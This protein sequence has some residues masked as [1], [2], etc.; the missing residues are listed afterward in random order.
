MRFKDARGYV[1]ELR[2]GAYDKG[3]KGASALKGPDGKMLWNKGEKSSTVS[4]AKGLERAV[5]AL[6]SGDGGG[7]FV[8]ELEYRGGENAGDID[9]MAQRLA[10]SGEL[11]W[12][13]GERSSTVASSKWLERRPVVLADGQGGFIVVY[14]ATAPK[15]DFEGDVDL[16]AM[17]LSPAGEMMWNEAKQAVDV[18][19]GKGLERNPCAVIAGR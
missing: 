12:N 4:T 17:R 8:F 2:P 14:A 16:E 15:G 19:A 3:R 18:A 7:F 11:V 13:K 9:V 10:V 1:F 6:P 5:C